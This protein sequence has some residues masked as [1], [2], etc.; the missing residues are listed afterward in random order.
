M[1]LIIDQIIKKYLNEGA[2]KIIDCSDGLDQIVKK[3]V[4]NKSEYIIKIPKDRLLRQLILKESFVCKK[5]ES[6]KYFPKVIFRQKDFIIQTCVK[7][8]SL[9][10]KRT[11]T[12][13]EIAVYYDL[14]KTIKKL[15]QI[16]SRGW[17]E[18]LSNG[19]GKF[20]SLT[21]YIKSLVITDNFVRNYL[22]DN[23]HLFDDDEIV[24]LHGDL[25]DGNILVSNDELSGIIDF[26][27]ACA[28]Y[29]EYDFAKVYL[30]KSKA[31][32]EAFISGYSL[33]RLDMKKLDYMATF[34]LLYLIPFYVTRKE[35]KKAD[36]LAKKLATIISNEPR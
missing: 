2:V 31:V 33:K 15:H 11:D 19:N 13:N 10:V 21:T 1:K 29:K 34:H 35:N 27:D 24:L 6:N 22:L 5:M 25:T 36:R 8:K 9:Q 26:G 4:T 18:L 20:K 32:F 12:K 7:G 17:G 28:G 14:G 16:K 30:E 23:A 3:V